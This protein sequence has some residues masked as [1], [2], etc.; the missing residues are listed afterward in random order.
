MARSRDARRW[1]EWRRRMQRFEEGQ[2]SVAAFCRDEGVSDAS[3]YQWRRRLAEP[4]VQ[5]LDREAD[6]TTGFRPV[7][8]LT[9]THIS[10]RLPGGTR[11]RVPSSDPQAVRLVIETLAHLDTQRVGGGS[12]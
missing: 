7:R 5:E 4:S 3:F 6:A 8:V 9:A 11:L 12:C 1:Q 2:Q 10:V